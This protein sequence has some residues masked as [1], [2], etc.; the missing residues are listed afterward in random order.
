MLVS[1]GVFAV[2]LLIG[3]ISLGGTIK[4][5]PGLPIAMLGTY[6]S[7]G[8]GYIFVRSRKRLDRLDKVGLGLFSL[9]PFGTFFV[10]PV[11]EFVLGEP[12]VGAVF[13]VPMFI[14][15]GLV[16]ER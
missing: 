11:Q 4:E 16:N 6:S 15:Y 7:F 8:A 10:S 9:V 2:T 5:V 13:A 3:D 14:A 1:F 12:L